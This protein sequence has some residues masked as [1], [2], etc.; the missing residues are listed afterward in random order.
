MR[1]SDVDSAE[2]VPLRI[3][4]QGGKVG[5]DSSEAPNNE[6]CDVLNDDEAG[7]NHA[8][9]AGVLAPESAPLSVDA[10][11]T[12]R[13]ADVLA[14]ESTTD[15]VDMLKLLSCAPDVFV[16]RGVRPVLRE[17]LAAVRIDLDLPYGVADTGPL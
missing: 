17:H 9:D 16:P 12:P 13:V 4:P 14:G 1:R 15:D 6:G 2:T 11:A 5:E 10:L 8:N 7:S 3:E